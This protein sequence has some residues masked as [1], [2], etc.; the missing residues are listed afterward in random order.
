MLKNNETKKWN[1]IED[2]SN[3][4]VFEALDIQHQAVQFVALV[5]KYLMEEKE[6]DSHTNMEY[7]WGMNAFVGRMLSN[8]TRLAVNTVDLKLQLVDSGNNILSEIE[9]DGKTKDEVFVELKQLL[10]EKRIDVT[11]MK[12]SLH[13]SIPQHDLDNGGKFHLN[14]AKYLEINNNYR[15]NAEIVL[16]E[17]CQKF[18]FETEFRVWPHHFDTGAFIPTS[19]E[20]NGELSQYIGLGY[21]IP[22]S[23]VDEPY[24]YLSFWSAERIPELETPLP[25]KQ[26]KWMMPAWSG[27]ILK[28]SDIKEEKEVQSQH[29]LVREFFESGIEALKPYLLV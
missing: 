12:N 13:Y 27:A 1:L 7:N 25:I 21:A 22:D 11:K 19:F 3:E 23:M 14:D 26:G 9:M 29:Q 8:K 10:S 16:N 17:I 15:Q 5:G 24:F 28:I 2:V 4:K 18:K 20:P 6:D